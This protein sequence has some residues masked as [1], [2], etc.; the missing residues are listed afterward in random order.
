M[1]KAELPLDEQLVRFKAKYGTIGLLT[2]EEVPVYY[3]TLTPFE[4]TALSELEK[5]MPEKDWMDTVLKIA[6]LHPEILDFKL[7]GSIFVIHNAIMNTSLPVKDDGFFEVEEYRAWAEEVTKSNAA[8]LLAV[9]ITN[10]YPAMN[11]L[12]LLE[13]PMEK[14]LKLGALVEK[15]TQQDVFGDGTSSDASDSDSLKQQLEQENRKYK[16]NG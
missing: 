1:Y 9:R 5:S 2:I 14:L 3:R 7:A 15:I 8:L 6:V 4:I 10:L 16:T 13:T 11:L 12:Q